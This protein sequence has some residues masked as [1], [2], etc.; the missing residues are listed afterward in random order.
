MGEDEE[1]EEDEV[2]EEEEEE[3][4]E[5]VARPCLCSCWKACCVGGREGGKD[6]KGLMWIN[7]AGTAAF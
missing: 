3:E 7:V 1:G 2:E 6:V 5:G 4:E